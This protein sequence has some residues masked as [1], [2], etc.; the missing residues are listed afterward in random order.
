MSLPVVWQQAAREDMAALLYF[1]A[2]QNP[3]AARDLKMRIEVA[4]QSLAEFPYRAP[5]GRV[6]NTRE[7]LAHPNYWIIYRVTLT[8]V[9]IVNVL[10]ARREYP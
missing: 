7:L 4:A 5:V 2:E 1:V 6:P 8:A 3:D 10:H 9:E